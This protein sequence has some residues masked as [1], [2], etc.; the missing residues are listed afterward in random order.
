P[1]LENYGSERQH[2]QNFYEPAKPVALGQGFIGAVLQSGR[3]QIAGDPEQELSGN[4]VAQK[5]ESALAVPM[6]IENKKIGV[7][8][9]K[10][11]GT[12]QFSD[13]QLNILTIIARQTAISLENASLLEIQKRRANH[14]YLI[15][16][17]TKN[18]ASSFDFNQFAAILT[19]LLHEKFEYT[20]VVLLSFDEETQE[21]V[22][23]HQNG[24]YE[25][26][27]PV[28][29]RLPVFEGVLGKAVREQKLINIPN[30][31]RESL[32]KAMIPEIQ[33]ELIVPVLSG[34]N[35]LGALVL[36]S[37]QLNDFSEN[38]EQAMQIL[39][40]QIAIAIENMRLF[41]SAKEN[42]QLANAAN[43]AK[44]EF[45]ANMSHEIRTPMN[46]IIGMTDLLLETELSEEQKDFAAAVKTSGNALLTIINDILDFSK[47]E[48][49]KMELEEIDFD[50]RQL[51]EN[52]T[53]TLA[54]RAYQK[55]I[56]IFCYIPP[57]M[58]T[59]L[60]G[61]PV[62]IRQILVNL[63]GNAIKFTETGQ[64]QIQIQTE[65]EN[66]EGTTLRFSIIDSGIGIK[67]DRLNKIFESFTQADGNTTRKFGGT[68]LGLSIS[69]Q[70]VEMM[71]GRI[72]VESKFGEGSNFSF[73]ITLKK[74]RGK[75]GNRTFPPA[76]FENLPVLVVDDNAVSRKIL[77]DYLHGFKCKTVQAESGVD[78]YQEIVLA[79]RAGTPFRLVIMDAQMPGMDGI[80]TIKLLQETPKI[81]EVAIVILTSIEQRKEY[82]QCHDLSF[83][84]YLVKPVKLDQVYN[85]LDLV[86][87]GKPAVEIKRRNN[88][89]QQQVN[90]DHVK[91]L[92]AEDNVVNQKLALKLLEKNGYKADVAADGKEVLRALQD[93][94]YD[95]ILMDVQMPELD[96]FETTAI[97]RAEEKSN[98]HIPIVAMT[99]HAMKGDRERCLEAGM[100]DYL[101]KPI[102]PAEVTK[103][104]TRWVGHIDAPEEPV[105]I[106]K[107][108]TPG[109][110]KPVNL[111][112]LYEVI[113]D[114]LDMIAEM[115]GLFLGNSRGRIKN[116]VKAL[117][118]Q[119]C[120][121]IEREAHALKGASG[122]IGA[123]QLYELCQ[124]LEDAGEAHNVRDATVLFSPLK[125]E[126]DRVQQYLTHD[127]LE[128]HNCK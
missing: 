90:R 14:F 59:T 75:N 32:Y 123:A 76:D 111:K 5:N 115:I 49:G 101:A 13:K 97:I 80:Q 58:Q 42:A 128:L 66:K 85:L 81:Q 40:D 88:K 119:D 17:V 53:D 36:G 94:H 84:G 52:V 110:A 43:K 26:A 12:G 78:A 38:D 10:K 109:N 65:E 124:K 34:Q 83:F 22:V 86:V 112:V 61:D 125:Q 3:G 20:H 98:V 44:S 11:A 70:L 18:I 45:L 27:V 99:A 31:R 106:E 51:A 127:I 77:C 104:L 64:V 8:S 118:K 25:G 91:I 60:I 122:G 73:R 56:E 92:L 68:G 54:F 95:L 79:Q 50:L 46:G 16:E 21:L 1:R 57:T 117:K 19:A 105:K 24:K 6:L 39:S 28:G 113:G 2:Q 37:H 69:Q 100:D 35:L 103:A 4:F 89:P 74:Q 82:R 47:I 114:D 67:E 33:S 71:N 116:L 15:S 120:D 48:A 23:T 7:L 126:F 108:T 29:Q 55:G 87:S 63:A 72:W 102:K 30:V 121:L 41:N 107:T 9:V 62:R 96:G 93:K